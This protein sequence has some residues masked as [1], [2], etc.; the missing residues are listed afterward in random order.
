MFFLQVIIF[1][2]LYCLMFHCFYKSPSC[3]VFLLVAGCLCF[4]FFVL[5]LLGGFVW[6]LSVLK[7]LIMILH[8][9]FSAGL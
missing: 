4:F 9:F 6:L 3:G 8:W 5:F 2:L 1:N 7:Y